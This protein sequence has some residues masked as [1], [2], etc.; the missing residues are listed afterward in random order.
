MNEEHKHELITKDEEIAALQLKLE[1]G[2]DNSID[3][4]STLYFA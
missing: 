3:M 1:P 2:H 4:S